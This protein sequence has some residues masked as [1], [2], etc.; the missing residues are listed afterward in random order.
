VN[1]TEYLTG[2]ITRVTN[3]RGFKTSTRYQVY[4]APSTDFP[5]QIDAPQGQQTVIVRDV[6]G[7]PLTINRNGP[8]GS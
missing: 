6:F 3:P 1:T 7:K 8:G 4:D 2:F 5:I